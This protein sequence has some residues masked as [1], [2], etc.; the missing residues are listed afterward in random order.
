MKHYINVSPSSRHKNLKLWETHGICSTFC[1][2]G[3]DIPVTC[4]LIVRQGDK[5]GR[6]WNE[7][8]FK[9]STTAPRPVTAGKLFILTT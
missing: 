8:H 2:N 1:Q 7:N 9:P 5:G 6:L 4:I 3:I